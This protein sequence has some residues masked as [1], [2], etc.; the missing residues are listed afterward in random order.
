M[1]A[2]PFVGRGPELR[3]LRSAVT[4]A[5]A[6]QRRTVLVAGEAG[7]GKTRLGAEVAAIASS[8]PVSASKRRYGSASEPTAGWAGRAAGRR[9]ASSG[10]NRTSAAARG[11][12]RVRSRSDG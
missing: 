10:Q 8:S 11:P 3:R 6:G 2:G 7:I 5:A 12:S 4:E 9:Q 1:V